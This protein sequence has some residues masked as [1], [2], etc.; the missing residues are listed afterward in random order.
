M[1]VFKFS[2]KF[3]LNGKWSVRK[4]DFE[5]Y[6]VKWQE[7]T[8]A[9]SGYIEELA[10]PSSNP[11]YLKGIY[12]SC[13]LAFLQLYNNS[14]DFPIVYVFP[15]LEKE[16]AWFQL[17]SPDSPCE[18]FWRGEIDGHA[19]LEV[20]EITDKYDKLRIAQKVAEILSKEPQVQNTVCKE[21]VKNIE[22]L[23]DFWMKL[24]S[25]IQRACSREEKRRGSRKHSAFFS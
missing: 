3:E 12:S 2:G 24:L 13:R 20:Q 5:G 14:E 15:E 4:A 23:N 8:D 10:D 11:K 7:E 18:F 17:G 6:F 9:I 1:H 21:L 22:F 25:G 16:G 19:K